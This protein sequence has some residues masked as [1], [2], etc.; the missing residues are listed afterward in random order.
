MTLEEFYNYV[1]E[2]A[3]TAKGY[4]HLGFS[5]TLALEKFRLDQEAAQQSVQ[6]DGA[7]ELQENE[8]LQIHGLVNGWAE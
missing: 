6:S 5:V 4:E 2:A 1:A 7:T 8:A 3:R